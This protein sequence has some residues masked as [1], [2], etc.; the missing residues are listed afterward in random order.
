MDI[1][2][3]LDQGSFFKMTRS[4]G[5]TGPMNASSLSSSACTINDWT[6]MGVVVEPAADSWQAGCRCHI[7]M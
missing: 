7:G 5:W 1:A 3:L 2:A 4:E 6:G